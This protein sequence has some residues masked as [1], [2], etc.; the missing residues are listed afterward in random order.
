MYRWEFKR[1]GQELKFEADG[2][3]TLNHMGLMVDAAI[4]GLGIAFVWAGTARAALDS[5]E[6][7]TIL[8][9]WTPPFDGH[10]LYYPSH[11]LVP[12]GLRAFV[13]VIKDVERG[14]APSR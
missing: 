6:L 8:E 10:C 2:P 14:A 11:R 3:V 5:G 12:V 13:N 4:K 1:H 7:V 9:D